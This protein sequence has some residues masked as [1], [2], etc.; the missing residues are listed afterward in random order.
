MSTVPRTI[1]YQPISAAGVVYDVSCALNSNTEVAANSTARPAFNHHV[2]V[3]A[4][5]RSTSVK[6]PN[7]TTAPAIVTTSDGS[8]RSTVHPMA[9]HDA[10]ANSI[11]PQMPSRIAAKGEEP[12]H[13]M[14]SLP[15][16][17]TKS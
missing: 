15:R 12:V 6:A 1:R 8:S 7:R 13:D 3:P 17:P 10:A 2:R 14:R 4:Q 16:V 11:R 5:A 9:S